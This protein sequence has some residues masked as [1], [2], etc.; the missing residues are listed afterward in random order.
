MAFA[1]DPLLLPKLVF[2]FV[3]LIKVIFQ[4][5]GVL[6]VQLMNPGIL[7]GQMEMQVLQLAYVSILRCLFLTMKKQLSKAKKLVKVSAKLFLLK[8]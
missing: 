2:M 5:R 6:F 4:E 1:V 8:K 3:V 7:C